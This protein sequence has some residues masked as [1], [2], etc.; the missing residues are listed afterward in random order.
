MS[1]EIDEWRGGAV[2]NAPAD[3]MGRSTTRLT[4]MSLTLTDH[5]V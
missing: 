2:Q 3:E 4:I 1:Q 5:I